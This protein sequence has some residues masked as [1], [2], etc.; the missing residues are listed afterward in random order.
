[1]PLPGEPKGTVEI[2]LDSV[3]LKGRQVLKEEASGLHW[4]NRMGT[5]G[6][7]SNLEEI[8]DAGGHKWI[9]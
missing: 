6:T 8:K 7:N 1:M 2:D 4:A 5:R 3:D 9:N